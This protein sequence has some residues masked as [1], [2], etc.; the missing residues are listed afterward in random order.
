M[1]QAGCEHESEVIQALKNGAWSE[2]LRRHAAACVECGEALRV[3]ETLRAEALRV[4]ADCTLPDS[5]WVLERA[6]RRAREM[7]VARLR[8]M[9]MAARI[10][11]AGYAAAVV[12]W[13]ARGYAASQYREVASAMQG[14]AGGFALLGAAA[15]AVCVAAGLWPILRA[16]SERR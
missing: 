1:K 3:A 7:A 6:R 12:C 14:G 9:L 5:Y 13:V 2:A 15:A 4:E 11:A 10:V 8:R 16:G